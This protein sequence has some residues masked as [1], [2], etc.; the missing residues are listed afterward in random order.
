MLNSNNDIKGDLIE[1]LPSDSKPYNKNE[2]DLMNM[3]FQDNNEELNNLF[4]GVY[5]PMLIA[6]LVIIFNLPP[7][8]EAIHKFIPITKTS[9]YF[10]IV[11][12]AIFISVLF[13]I[14]KNANL[15]RKN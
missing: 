6:L 14:L 7:L 1:E 4:K 3:V 13:W 5:E 11:I 12:K 10:T 15:S 9:I 2:I 8:I